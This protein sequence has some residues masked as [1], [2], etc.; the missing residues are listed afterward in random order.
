MLHEAPSAYDELAQLESKSV[1]SDATRA[2]PCELL[3]MVPAPLAYDIQ[4]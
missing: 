3:A 4:E 1:A 2:M